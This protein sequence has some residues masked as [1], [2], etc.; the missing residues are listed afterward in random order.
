MKSCWMSFIFECGFLVLFERSVSSC[1]IKNVLK[2]VTLKNVL[3]DLCY[4]KV[5]LVSIIFVASQSGM[6]YYTHCVKSV[7]IRS[8][9][10][11]YFLASLRIQSKWGKIR[12]RKTPNTLHAV[13]LFIIFVMKR[14]IEWCRVWMNIAI[15]TCDSF[16]PIDTIYKLNYK[17]ENLL[18]KFDKISK[19]FCTLNDP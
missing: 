16:Q 17:S 5:C 2:N 15:F 1:S 8:F 14:F 9:S 18:E 12:T 6:R 10:I 3:L 13:I 4:V 11:P 19:I 7:P